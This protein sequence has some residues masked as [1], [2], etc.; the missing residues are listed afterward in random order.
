[1]IIIKHDY[2]VVIL[3]HKVIIEH[4]MKLKLLR[5]DCNKQVS[6]MSEGFAVTRANFKPCLVNNLTT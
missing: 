1:M 4:I 3:I 5:N 2:K 6:P